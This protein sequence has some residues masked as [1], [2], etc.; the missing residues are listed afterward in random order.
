MQLQNCNKRV[1]EPSPNSEGF[2]SQFRLGGKV[3]K[4]HQRPSLKSRWD[5]CAIAM[6]S[7]ALTQ[8]LSL[9]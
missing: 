4:K 3:A 6:I 1:R 8:V 7:L 9:A 5:T 2:V